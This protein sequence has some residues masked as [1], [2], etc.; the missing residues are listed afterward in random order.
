MTSLRSIFFD[1]DDTLF[2]TTDFATK[3]RRNALRAMIRAGL[4]L[5]EEEALRELQEVLG[6]FS[7]NYDHHFDR[8]L[9]RV[10]PR[11][12]VRSNPALIVAAG[13]AE[14]HD[15]KFRELKPFPDVIE[16]LQALQ[17]AGIQTGVITHGLAIKQA[18]KLVRLG[19]L[20]YL[21]TRAIF[22]SDQVGI[23]KPNPKLYAHALAEVGREPGEVMYVGDNPLHDVAPPQSLGLIAVWASRAAK[24]TLEGTNIT[25][26]H[27]IADFGELREILREDYSVDC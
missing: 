7:T 15:T 22:I 1:V 23:S 12:R 13:V 19:L 6:E 11:E 9:Q 8:L 17:K 20:P 5:P 4:D 18:E 10:R 2:S 25:P 27:Q 14:Y 3:A 26:D 16:L 24:H 21:D